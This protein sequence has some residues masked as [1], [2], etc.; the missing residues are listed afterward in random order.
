M[1]TLFSNFC[2]FPKRRNREIFQPNREFSRDN[3]ETDLSIRERFNSLAAASNPGLE[4]SENCLCRPW[5]FNA[6]AVSRS[7][8][9]T[10]IFCNGRS[11]QEPQPGDEHPPAFGD[12]DAYVDAIRNFVLGDDAPLPASSKGKRVLATVLF[13]D[14]VGSNSPPVVQHE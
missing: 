9:K 8:S 14:I 10:L 5:W 11:F 2:I 12:S 13:T 1:L 6:I 7:A 3:R 4:T